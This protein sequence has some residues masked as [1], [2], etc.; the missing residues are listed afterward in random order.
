MALYTTKHN[1]QKY[2]LYGGFTK[3]SGGGT[4][5]ID[6]ELQ[7][8]GKGSKYIGTFNCYTWHLVVEKFKEVLKGNLFTTTEE[9][10]KV[11]KDYIRSKGF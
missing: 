5:M 2:R 6:V 8:V 1:K 7:I 9:F 11:A 10:A 4:P 3:H